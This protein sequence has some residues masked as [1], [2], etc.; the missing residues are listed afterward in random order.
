ML[1]LDTVTPEAI[2]AVSQLGVIAWM[3]IITVGMFFIVYTLIKNKK[4]NG[5]NGINPNSVSVAVQLDLQSRLRA[6]EQ[7]INRIDDGF[8]ALERR[9]DHMEEFNDQVEKMSKATKRLE[10][11]AEAISLLRN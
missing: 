10:A 8:E 7:T 11:L 4:G 6:V 5:G 9:L 2:G 1:L 3:G